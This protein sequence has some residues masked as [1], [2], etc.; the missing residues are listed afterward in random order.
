MLTLGKSTAAPPLYPPNPAAQAARVPA[1]WWRMSTDPWGAGTTQWPGVG[2]GAVGRQGPSPSPE[3]LCSQGPE[4]SSLFPR[5]LHQ[6][7]IRT[8]RPE[9]QQELSWRGPQGLGLQV[10][11]C[12]PTLHPVWQ[13]MKSSSR[14]SGGGAGHSACPL[15][16]WTLCPPPIS[17]IHS[18]PHGLPGWSRAG[19]GLVQAP[20]EPRQPHLYTGMEGRS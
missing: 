3:A 6:Q 4:G 18:S 17:V 10:T 11:R 5:P 20:P 8:E 13:G 12:D 1:G 16:R 9:D 7:G 2:C 15:A 14:G 19:G